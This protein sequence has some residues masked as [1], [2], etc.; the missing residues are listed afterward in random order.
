MKK[1][2][3]L[4][5]VFVVSLLPMLLNQFGGMRGVQEIRGLIILACPIALISLVLFFVGV[6][7]PSGKGNI[8]KISTITGAV[9][10]VIAEIY[11]FFTWHYATITGEIS[12]QNS[13]K[14]AYPEFY[15]GLVVSIIAAIACAVIE[16]MEI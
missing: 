3:V 2:I 12:L 5:A 4:S 10:M 6:W 14:L 11:K 9:L 8:G 15:I 13:L 16:N 7:A 1:K